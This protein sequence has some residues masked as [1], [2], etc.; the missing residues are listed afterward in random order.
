MLTAKSCELF[1]MP[2]FQFAQ[3]KKYC[4][5]E[6][7]RIKAEYKA[8]WEIWK[9]LNLEIAR[10]LGPPF[11]EPHIEKWCNGWQVRAH[12]FAYYKYEFNKNSAAIIS[13]LLN[14]RRLQVSLDWHCYRADRSQINVHQYNRWLE[15][16]DLDKAQDFEIWKGRESEYDDLRKVSQIRQEDLTFDNDEDFWCIG[17][18]V[19][20]AD[21][22]K[23]DCV[24]FI[25]R[26]I[27]DLLP[28]YEA[29]HQ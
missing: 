4:P 1:E 17:R 15:A 25:Y 21:L 22:D 18:N 11:A 28:F 8:H 29:C 13:V 14:R 9:K 19:E 10:L 5:E 12:F 3:M 6:I 24:E 16:L 27:R 2:F 20:K 26:T 7:P 23:I